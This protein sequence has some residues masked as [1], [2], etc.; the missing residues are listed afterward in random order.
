MGVGMAKPPGLGGHGGCE[1]AVRPL[2]GGQE[3]R[4]AGTGPSPAGARRCG[5]A[6]AGGRAGGR[7]DAHGCRGDWPPHERRCAGWPATGRSSGR[8]T[9]PARA[10]GRPRAGGSGRGRAPATGRTPGTRPPAPPGR[11]SPGSAAARSPAAAGDH[12]AYPATSA[13]PPQDRRGRSPPPATSSRGRQAAQALRNTTCALLAH[14]QARSLTSRSG[15]GS[16]SPHAPIQLTNIS[17]SRRQPV[18]FGPSL[19]QLGITCQATWN[20][21]SGVL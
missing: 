16:R 15:H 11:A 19:T 6:E 3:D 12:H 20:Y 9:L 1:D 4:R 8:T 5:D 2:G 10:A 18:S 14:G 7:P 13:V 21:K 17:T